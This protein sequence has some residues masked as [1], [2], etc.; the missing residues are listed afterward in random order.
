V[1]SVTRVPETAGR[2]AGELTADDA[3]TLLRSH[4]ATRLAREAFVRFRYGDGFSHS[5]AL[6]LQLC[7]AFIPLAVAFVGLSGELYTERLGVVLR[8]TL[9]A[10]T[11][12]ASDP[13][14]RST[15]ER[16]QQSDGEADEFAL[17]LG[18]LVAVV[19]LTV[20]MAQIERSANRIYGVQ[21]DRPTLSKYGRALL[22]AGGAGLPAVAGVLL[23]VAGGEAVAAAEEVYGVNGLLAAVLRWPVGVGLMLGSVMVMLRHAPRRRQPS[24]SWLALA[25]GVVLVLW[26][27][28]TGLL[29][30]YVQVSDAFGAVYGP[31]T[32]VMALL[33][34]AQLSSVAVFLGVALAA[35]L[36]AVRAGCGAVT[37][38]PEQR[39][40]FA[41]AGSTSGS[42]GRT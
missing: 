21:R 6:G 32:G 36:E 39:S 40:H 38:D 9:L 22:L 15:L 1:S 20:A 7:L 30:V 13:M 35:Q 28:F 24:W 4:G 23:L 3:W 42:T 12:G 34:W 31:L 17:W 33:L 8:R 18:M 29:V 27:V 19:S 16:E 5:R 26:L 41:A 10:L 14:I 25:A 2:S 11:P 37:H